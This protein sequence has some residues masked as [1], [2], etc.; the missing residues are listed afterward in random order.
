MAVYAIGD[1]HGCFTTLQTLLD[2]INY[3]NTRDVLWFTGDLVDRGAQSLE[4]L[5]FV[6]SLK[7][8]AVVVLGNHDLHLLAVSAGAATARPHNTFQSTLS[9]PDRQDLMDWLVSRPLLHHDADLGFTLVHAGF[10]PQWDLGEA[11]RLAREVE[12]A[13]TGSPDKFFGHLFG[14]RP[15]KW[16]DALTPPDRWR[17]VINAFTRLRYCDSDGRMAL[18]HNV[19]PVTKPPHLLPW[20]DVPG[21]CPRNSKI[22]FGHWSTLGPCRGTDFVALDSGCGWGGELTAA[23]IDVSPMQ[24]Y[25]VPGPTEGLPDNT[26][27]LTFPVP[28]PEEATYRTSRV[29]RIIPEIL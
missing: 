27:K 6:K 17:I 15:D 14:D 3:D 21:K 23:R 13:M 19:S 22:I 9:A 1:V 28:N 29:K 5:R 11:K 8:H 24:F 2:R 18:R 25:A 7:D 10:L 16:E 12:R 20:F 26:G 4:V